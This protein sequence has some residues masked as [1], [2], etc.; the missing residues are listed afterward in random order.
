[1]LDHRPR[2]LNLDKMHAMLTVTTDQTGVVRE[3]V[4]AAQDQGKLSDPLFRAFAE[5]AVRA[6]L[7]P[8]C[9]ALPLPRSMLGK[10]NVLTFR[11]SP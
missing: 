5:R 6:V 1:M 3:A 2:R 4:V 9:A 11:F 10:I 7:D 8:A